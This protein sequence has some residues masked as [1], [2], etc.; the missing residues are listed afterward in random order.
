[1]GKRDEP[2]QSQKGGELKKRLKGVRKR[3]KVHRHFGCD[4]M[5]LKIQ[6]VRA[7][8]QLDH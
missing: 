3:K 4:V 2:E 5:A 8:G 7:K 6:L 1:V